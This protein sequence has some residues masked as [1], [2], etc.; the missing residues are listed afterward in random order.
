MANYSTEAAPLSPGKIFYLVTTCCESSVALPVNLWALVLIF[1]NKRSTIEAEILTL[2]L[3]LTEIFFC[4]L[5]FLYLLQFFTTLFSMPLTD[6]YRGSTTVART[7]FQ[8]HLCID[9]YL[10]VVHPIV[11][12]RYKQIQYRVACL[13]PLW[14]IAIVCGLNSIFFPLNPKLISICALSLLVP[15]L[16]TEIVCSLVIVRILRKSGPGERESQEKREGNALKR[17][18]VKIITFLALMAFVNNLPFILFPAFNPKFQDTL[19][20]VAF[21]LSTVGSSVHGFLGAGGT[22]ADASAAPQLM[23]TP[24]GHSYCQACI[25]SYWDTSKTTSRASKMYQCPLCKESFNRRPELHI[26]RTLKEI[27]EHFKRAAAS[28]EA[29]SWEDHSS[30][31]HRR[32]SVPNRRNELTEGV[33]NEMVNRFQK[34]STEHEDPPP[35]YTPPRRYT[36]SSAHDQDPDLPLCPLHLRGLAYFCKV[37]NVCVCSACVESS[38]HKGHNISPAK[39]EWQIRKSQLGL[40]D[41][42]LEVLI[43]ERESK[44]LEIHNTLRDIKVAAEIQ[45]NETMSMFV[46]LVANVERCQSEML[47]VIEMSRRAAEHR[48]QRQLKDLEEELS[49][50][51]KKR[52]ALNQLAQTNNCVQFLTSF[53]SVSAPP[54]TRD[55][56]SAAVSSELPS[57][58]VLRNITQVMERFKDEMCKLTEVWKGQKLEVEQAVVKHS[59]KVRRVQ[60][61][62]EDITLDPNTAHPRLV[63]S[64][65]GKQVFCGDRHQPVP[66]NPERFDRVVCALGREG[67]DCGRH[68]WEVEVGSKTDWDLGVA[69][70]S[71]T[72]KG[73]ITVS[74]AHGYWFLSLRDKMD[75]A[76]RTEPSTPVTVTQHPTRI[77]IFLDYDKG[78][79]SFYNVDAKMLIY[80]FSDRFTGVIL[81]FFSPC[82]NKSG[83]NEAPLTICPLATIE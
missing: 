49:E 42:K 30:P 59:P 72:R 66:E 29:R 53:P 44:A 32:T 37:E 2:N 52:T 40:V 19:L 3:L 12:I 54:Q 82:T 57:A 20:P 33:M 16:S 80:T 74:P 46:N 24:C 35:A 68:Y 48:T 39:R 36:V 76:F 62:A 69:S 64:V 13:V 61:Y 8:W 43:T 81:P 77:G 60:E 31:S 79:V 23:S 38:E 65:D 56:S 51:K 67:F 58:A 15:S 26:N 75:Y 5:F 45:T 6:F 14:I 4:I 34:T 63:V 7:L 27:T 17:R 47:E 50:L 70:R 55:W 9:R 18:A 41:A 28:G 83:R 71:V 25:S 1:S 22:G 73:K 78:I 21:A 10:A 11:F